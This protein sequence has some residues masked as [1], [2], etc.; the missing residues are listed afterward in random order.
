[1]NVPDLLWSTTIISLSK[2]ERSGVTMNG[3]YI[4]GYFTEEDHRILDELKNE[5]EENGIKLRCRDLTGSMMQSA[6]DFIDIDLVELGWE[7]IK[8]L[9]IKGGTGLVIFWIKKLWK[10][11]TKD[12]ETPVPFTLSISGIPSITGTENIKC[13]ISGPLS[14]DAKEIAILKGYELASKIEEHQYQLLEKDIYY[15]AV[16]AH[17]FRYDPERETYSE[18]DIAAEVRKKQEENTHA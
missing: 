3:I 17:L 6:L 15:T 18:M 14:D 1:M 16:N 10:L 11:I 12:R 2:I 9:A 4:S 8:A 5:L 7:F 13:K